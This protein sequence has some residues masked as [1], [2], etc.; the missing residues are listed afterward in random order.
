VMEYPFRYRFASFHP[1]ACKG[2]SPKFVSS[3]L[4]T[5]APE[6]RED[7]PLT[8]SALRSRGPHV[9][10]ADGYARCRIAP[11]QTGCFRYLVLDCASCDSLAS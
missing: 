9:V 1:S 4:H 3:I 6:K 10:V 2:D 8:A 11:A 7:G 5:V